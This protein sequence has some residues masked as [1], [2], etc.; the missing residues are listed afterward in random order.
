MDLVRGAERDRVTG[1]GSSLFYTLVTTVDG[2]KLFISEHLPF[3]F[4]VVP[5]CDVLV[6]AS[7]LDGELTGRVWKFDVKG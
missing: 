1:L 6:E 4:L 3:F 7:W 5:M 2:T